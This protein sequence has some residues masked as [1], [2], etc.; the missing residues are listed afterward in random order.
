MAELH[1]CGNNE[2]RNSH[3]ITDKIR[4]RLTKIF[5]CGNKSHYGVLRKY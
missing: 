4:P 2:R 3:L 1:I 5:L